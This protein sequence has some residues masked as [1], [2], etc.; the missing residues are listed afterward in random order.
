VVG[1]DYVAEAIEDAHR[2]AQINGI[3]NVNFFAGD[4]KELLSDDFLSR[5]GKPDVII[6]DPPRAGVHPKV[7]NAL[8]DANPC[9]IVYVSCNPATQARDINLLS[10]HFELTRI[11][12]VDMFP[13][14][15]HVENVVLMERK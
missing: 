6:L 2:N 12:P 4:V 9:R 8:K 1:I 3:D 14:T 13:H 7:I 5:H 15:H 10:T 11:Q